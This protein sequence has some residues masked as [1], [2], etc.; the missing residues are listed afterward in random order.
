[1]VG[2][3][4]ALGW[5]S[6]LRELFV[7][8][9]DGRPV[10]GPVPE[11]LRAAV[12]QVLDAWAPRVDGVVAVASAGRPELVRHL[13]SGVAGHLGVPL[14]GALVPDP[15]APPGRHDVNSAQRLATV[16]HRLGMGLGDAALAGLP[17]RT[18]LLVDD[19]VG[20]GWTMTV[21][22]RLLRRHGAADVL[23]FALAVG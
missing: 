14:V 5:G 4:D 15:A 17:G 19:R 7:T 18:V 2:R 3:L 11:A 16:A 12:R 23:P 9:A 22:A 10:D 21:G 20:S 6:A 13:A 1:M 8:S